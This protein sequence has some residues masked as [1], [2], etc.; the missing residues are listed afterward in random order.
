VLF[1]LRNFQAIP[2]D[3]YKIRMNNNWCSYDYIDFLAKYSQNL[4]RL[5]NPLYVD[6]V[7]I[8]KRVVFFSDESAVIKF[9]TTA[10]WNVIGV[11]AAPSFHRICNIVCSF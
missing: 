7:A 6:V 4:P 3:I 11:F 5:W 9:L 10:I 2:S 1:D 8:T